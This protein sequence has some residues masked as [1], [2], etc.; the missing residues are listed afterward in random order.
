[1]Y[2][3]LGEGYEEWLGAS[4]HLPS[5][6]PAPL[7]ELGSWLLAPHILSHFPHLLMF[8]KFSLTSYSGP[9]SKTTDTLLQ[10]KLRQ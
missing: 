4:V 8:L 7:L 5:Y 6:I 3:G 2:R 10:G 9:C 1:M